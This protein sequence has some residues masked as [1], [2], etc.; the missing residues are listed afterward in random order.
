MIEYFVCYFCPGGN[1]IGWYVCDSL[2]RGG[3]GTCYATKELAQAEANK[4]NK[5]E[6]ERINN[7]KQQ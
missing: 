5:E 2:G 6:W 7:A 4:R 3:F 1:G